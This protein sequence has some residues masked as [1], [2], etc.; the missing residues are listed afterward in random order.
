MPSTAQALN[1]KTFMF[2]A[3]YAS[4][5]VMNTEEP[6]EERHMHVFD[7]GEIESQD[8]NSNQI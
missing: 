6:L 7:E 3:Q 8:F 5:K 2:T 1:E 4:S